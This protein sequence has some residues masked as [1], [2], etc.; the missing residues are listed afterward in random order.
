[1]ALPLLNGNA[2][3]SDM[4]EP[5]K[6]LGNFHLVEL[7]GRGGMGEVFLAIERDTMRPRAIKVLAPDIARR[8]N[9]VAQLRREGDIGMQLARYDSIVAVHD[10]HE[11]LLGDPAY[12]ERVLYLVMDFVDGV[13]LRQFAD[14][15]HRTMGER[16]PIHVVVHII[17]A[18]L[19]ALDAAHT[20]AIGETSLAVVHGD[21]NPGNVLISSR[22]EIRVTDFG[23]SRFAPQP[24]FV[25]RPVG[26]L[27][28]MAP[29]QYRGIVRPQNDLYA[30]GAVIHELLT[31]SP[32]LPESGG[33]ITLER[34]LLADPIPP[35]GRDGV[36]AALERLRRGLLEKD[37]DLRIP[38]AE[39]ALALLAS[40]D[41]RDRLQE[42]RV[43]Y[44]RMFGPPRSRLTRYLQAQGVSSGSFVMDVLLRHEQ[45]ATGQASGAQTLGI[46]ADAIPS[47]GTSQPEPVTS[48]DEDDGGMAWLADDEDA[49]KTQEHRR[50]GPRLSP[51]I[52]LDLPVGEPAPFG[53]ASTPT[54][55][56]APPAASTALVTPPTAAPE[57]DELRPAAT[58]SLAG[59]S[60]GTRAAG[61][62]LEPTDDEADVDAVQ[63]VP[64]RA[65]DPASKSAPKPHRYPPRPPHFEDGAPFQLRR[66]KR[67]VG[68][69]PAPA[70]GSEPDSSAT[71]DA[72][73]VGTGPRPGPHQTRPE[74]SPDTRPDAIPTT[75]AVI[76][77][78]PPTD[79]SA[80]WVRSAFVALTVLLLVA[81]GIGLVGLALTKSE[82]AIAF[83]SD[84]HAAATATTDG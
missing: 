63:T 56:E 35:L 33:P 11:V 62:L 74:R 59:D 26:T 18:L 57:V 20:H 76:R 77:R 61:P 73:N 47:S 30:V 28:Y 50:S 40:A 54:V 24:S 71:V 32:P 41:D 7:I 45:A 10:V 36:P 8:T 84:A 9:G 46:V 78:R 38:T 17:R 83:P 15:Y 13:N 72:A 39:K 65:A 14:R 16:L 22:G 12:P 1:M 19:R 44:R 70:E 75:P 48:A 49:V 21:I 5:F 25:S 66:P 34:K 3:T 68:Q 51:T 6:T 4:A 29:E 42:I 31:G 79:S 80:R 58:E 55:P 23:I 64:R 52:R 27:P 81:C 82:A 37:P 53:L 60:D 2:T 43:A 67:D 69:P